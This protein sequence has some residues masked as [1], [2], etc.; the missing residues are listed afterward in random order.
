[1]VASG[2]VLLSILPRPIPITVISGKTEVLEFIVANE[3][4]S[5][6]DGR[7]FRIYGNNVPETLIGQCVEGPVEPRLQSSVQYLILDRKIEVE[8]RP[9]SKKHL[10]LPN[11]IQNDSSVSIKTKNDGWKTIN[12]DVF[13]VLDTIDQ[14]CG[15]LRASR[16]PVWGP[17]RIGS[18]LGYPRDGANPVLIEATL[19]LYGRSVP[20]G[21]LGGGDEIYPSLQRPLSIP[22]G[23]QLETIERSIA[24]T[25]NGRTEGPQGPLIQALRGFLL[26]APAKASGAF[27]IRLSTEA[28]ELWLYPPGTGLAPEKIVVGLFT[29]V[30]GDPTTAKIQVALLAFMVLLPITLE[31]LFFFYVDVAPGDKD[32]KSE[33]QNQ[34]SDR[35]Q[36][37][38]VLHDTEYDAGPSGAENVPQTMT[39]EVDISPNN[40]PLEPKRK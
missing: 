38:D 40:E 23:S 18:P 11:N 8:I 5:T 9:P 27:E 4:L 12:G 6:F 16:F 34:D 15:E 17:G 2:W 25:E 29:Q 35:A 33:F 22:P 1:M 19:D 36:G 14:G 28:R 37:F 21:V 30:F 13:L 32:R 39:K 3:K 20:K 10:A 24:S 26:L 31:V 7:G